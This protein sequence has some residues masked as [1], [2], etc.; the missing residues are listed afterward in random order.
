VAGRGRPIAWAGSRT[1]AEQVPAVPN[2]VQEDRDAAVGLVSWLADEL[3]A[4]LAHPPVRSVEVLDPQE[5]PDPPGVLPAASSV[6]CQAVADMAV[7][8]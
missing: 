6:G 8:V 5:E 3:H 1:R 4:V 2:D 7:T